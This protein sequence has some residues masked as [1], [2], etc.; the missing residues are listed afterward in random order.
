M[1]ATYAKANKDMEAAMMLPIKRLD[2]PV[3]SIKVTL[4][5]LPGRLE[6]AKSKAFQYM[7]FKWTLTN[8]VL[9]LR[10][11]NKEQLT[12]WERSARTNEDGKWTH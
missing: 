5:R 11:R 3:R 4:K 12:Q 7:F 2:L 10:E 6:R 1:A 9:I 8:N